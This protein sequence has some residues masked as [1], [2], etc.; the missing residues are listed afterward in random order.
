MLDFVKICPS[1]IEA[2]L[3]LPSLCLIIILE[4]VLE[5]S[6]TNA[7]SPFNVKLVFRTRESFSPKSFSV[8]TVNLASVLSPTYQ[9]E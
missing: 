4:I 3:F 2:S 7:K 6:V 9:N 1:A 5:L 8:V